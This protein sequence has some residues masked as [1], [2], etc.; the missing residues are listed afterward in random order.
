M[1]W[2]ETIPLLN[3]EELTAWPLQGG[4]ELLL[5]FLLFIFK[6]CSSIEFKKIKE[7]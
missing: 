5:D 4:A 2:M 3:R 1:M 7:Y 6:V